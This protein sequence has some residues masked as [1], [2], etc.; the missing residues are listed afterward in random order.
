[1]NKEI[2]EIIKDFSEIF[3]NIV[4]AIT[5]IIGTYKNCKKSSKKSRKSRKG[6]K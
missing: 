6:K 2:I 4:I 1:M 3:L 5:T